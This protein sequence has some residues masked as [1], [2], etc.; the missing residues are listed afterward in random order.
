MYCLSP[1]AGSRQGDNSGCTTPRH[2]NKTPRT[3]TSARNKYRYIFFSNSGEFAMY[4]YNTAGLIPT[5]FL[6]F[7]RDVF[8]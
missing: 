4:L 1:F 8:K 3:P 5:I 6:F 7:K 2:E